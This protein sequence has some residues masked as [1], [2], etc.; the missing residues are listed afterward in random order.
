VAGVTVLRN[1][2]NVYV[3]STISYRDKNK[4]PQN[5]RKAFAIVQPGTNK[6]VFN[7]YGMAILKSQNIELKSLNGKYLSEIGKIV[8]FSCNKDELLYRQHEIN[9][10]NYIEVKDDLISRFFTIQNKNVQNNLKKSNNKNDTIKNP[11]NGSVKNLNGIYLGSKFIDST[12]FNYSALNDISDECNIT[13]KDDLEIK[14]YGTQFLLE[15]ISNSIGLTDIIKDVFPDKWKELLTL[16][17]YLCI[18]ETIC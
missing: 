2:K 8:D 5:F 3:Y 7:S 16:S 13:L 12:K 18:N 9:Y 4:K 6:L 1:R 11:N 17:F 14:T 15:H 10:S